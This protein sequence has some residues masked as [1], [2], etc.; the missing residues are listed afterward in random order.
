MPSWPLAALVFPLGYVPLLLTDSRLLRPVVLIPLAALLFVR[1][2]R[3]LP[4]PRVALLLAI[5]LGCFVLSHVVAA[6]T[7]PALGVAVAGALFGAAAW[8]LADR[9]AAWR[10]AHT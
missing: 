1:W 5:F 7:A 2:V 9:P 8:A 6:A 3:T 10:P 4:A